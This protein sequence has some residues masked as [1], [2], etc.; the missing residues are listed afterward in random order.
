MTEPGVSRPGRRG[1]LGGYARAGFQHLTAAREG[2]ADLARALGSTDELALL[3]GLSAAAD[4][5]TAL[6]VLTRIAEEEGPRLAALDAFAWRRLCLLV[7]SSP[8]LGEFLYR[9]PDLIDGIVARDGRL[10]SGDEAR[11]E[12]LA[13]V[14]PDGTPLVGEAGWNAL[15]IGYRALLAGVALFDLTSAGAHGAAP[16]PRPAFEAVAAALSSLADAALEAAIAVGRAT[17]LTEGAT[18]RVAP[19]K[20]ADLRFAVIAMGKCGAEE[21]N[22]VSDVDVM[23]IAEGDERAATALAR[24]VMRAIQDP[25]LE[26]P[27]WQVDPNLRPEGRQGPLVRTLSSMLSY[28]DRWAKAWEFQALIKARAC[29]GDLALGEEFVA[30]TRPLVWASANRED[31]V[32]SVQRMRERVTEHIAPEELPLQIKLGP[33][34]LRDIEFSV[35]LLQLVHGQHDEQL[36]LRGTLPAL[37]ALVEDGYVAR[38]DGE[39]L[40]E[41]YRTLRVLEHRLQLRDLRRTALMPSDDEGRRVLARASGLARDAKELSSL[42]DRV[43]REVRELHLKI[44]YA[45]LLSAVAALPDEE[46]VL[47]TAEAKARLSSIGF[48]DPDG[49]SRHLAALTSGPSRSAKI[50]RNLTPVLLQWLALGTDPDF[51]LL[52]FRK[53]SEANR[54]ASWYLRL[55]RDGS[56]AAERLTMLLA[57]SKY[58]AGLLEGYPEGVAWLERDALLE[59]PA[60]EALLSEMRSLVSRRP[61]AQSA[62]ERLR[63]VHRREILR[64]AMGRVVGVLDE[65]AVA[66][67]LDGAH[68]ALLDALLSAIR[69]HAGGESE[70]PEIA[71]VGM[72]RFGGGELGF[73][74]DIDLIAVARGGATGTGPVSPAAKVVTELRTLVSDPRFPVDLDFDLRPEGKNGPLVRSIDSYRSYYERWSATWEAQALL[75]ARHAAGDGS[76]SAEFF[77]MA[78]PIRYPAEFREEQ[79]RDVRRMKARVE[80]ERLPQGQDPAMHL[81]LGPGGISDVEWLVQLLQ[82]QHGAEHPELRTV[83]TLAALSGASRLGLIDADDAATL[84]DAWRLASTLRSAMRL[85]NGRGTDSLPRDWR[86]LAGIAGVLGLPRD[87]TSELVERWHTVSR[88][89]RAVFERE[90]FGYRE[91]E[92]FPEVQA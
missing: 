15:R 64:L 54:E 55:L 12:L 22:V 36:Q 30:G 20:F 86:D 38:S 6:A 10:P 28:Y 21:L 82:L 19:E 16:D 49:A 37:R 56:L 87:R 57:N 77:A 31:F 69:A 90:F 83:S 76:L 84:E 32:G 52:A 34:G 8:A 17:L 11:D 7:G 58:A 88:R 65:D 63:R 92:L 44:F 91:D 51:G 45:P 41:H 53:V 33:G 40:S 68:T 59:P 14:T 66:R 18:P 61:S 81:K 46:F 71:L 13:A 89:A 23:F 2:L 42:W 24:E 72:G 73:A 79:L 39:R 29:A 78:D 35:Q 43:R 50:L 9:H 27:L 70:A 62:A 5:D 74:S 25:A 47:G 3:D 75:R 1:E 67:G 60:P 26:L 48:L 4:P 85:W 80:G